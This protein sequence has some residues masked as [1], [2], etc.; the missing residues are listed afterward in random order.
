MTPVQPEMDQSGITHY[1]A[2]NRVRWQTTTGQ[3][4]LIVRPFKI[5]QASETDKHHSSLRQ[6]CT[7]ASLQTTQ[8][9]NICF[10][11]QTSNRIH[12]ILGHC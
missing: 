11:L 5:V 6:L 3:M 12:H 9:H 7:K 8:H 2:G 4:L 1:Q 10:H